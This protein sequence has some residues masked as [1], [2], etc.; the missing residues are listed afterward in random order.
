MPMARVRRQ[1][2]ADEPSNLLEG[3]GS[4]DVTSRSVTSSTAAALYAERSTAEAQSM[5][6]AWV[7][8]V[9]YPDLLA[10]TILSGA[11]GR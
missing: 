9:N 5:T 8:G 4:S 2:G 3:A 6:A 1:R 7:P 11:I 10:S